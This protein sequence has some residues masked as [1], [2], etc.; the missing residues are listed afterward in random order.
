L[1]SLQIFPK[2]GNFLKPEILA[3]GSLRN[4]VFF[5]QPFIVGC[6]LRSLELHFGIFERIE[7]YCFGEKQGGKTFFLNYNL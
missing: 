4:I 5:G 2:F 3:F 7:K 6:F 1:S